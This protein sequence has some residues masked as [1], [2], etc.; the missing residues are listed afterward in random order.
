MR[1]DGPAPAAG[2]IPF[3]GAVHVLADAVGDKRPPVRDP[4]HTGKA[5]IDLQ[6]PVIAAIAVP[7]NRAYD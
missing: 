1:P 5:P 2:I 3:D 7:V 4:L 6:A